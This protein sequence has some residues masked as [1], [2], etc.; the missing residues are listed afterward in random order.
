[1]KLRATHYLPDIIQLQHI[2]YKLYNYKVDEEEVSNL[3]VKDLQ[4]NCKGNGLLCS[5]Q[6][7]DTIN[8]TDTDTLIKLIESFCKAW[9][10]V[11]SFLPNY[12]V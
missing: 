4:D 9:T 7:C 2:L 3:T 10:A 11:E 6:S 12:G 5:Y 8:Y 1:M